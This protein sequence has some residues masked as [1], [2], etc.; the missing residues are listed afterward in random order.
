[1]T[2]TKKTKKTKGTLKREDTTKETI[3]YMPFELSDTK[4][5]I[6]FSDGNKKRLITMDARNLDQL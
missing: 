3:L 5:K 6:A 1:M 2:K 4:W